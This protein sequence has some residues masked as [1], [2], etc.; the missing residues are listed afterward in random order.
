MSGAN[1]CVVRAGLLIRKAAAQSAAAFFH[2]ASLAGVNLRKRIALNLLDGGFERF[3]EARPSFQCIGE[4]SVDD[5]RLDTANSLGSLVDSTL[6]WLGA[7]ADAATGSAS[8]TAVISA[9]A[10]LR[11]LL[12]IFLSP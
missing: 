2:A 1:V 12:L 7:A 8:P 5:V 3:A 9:S 10:L 6:I 11:F 4:R